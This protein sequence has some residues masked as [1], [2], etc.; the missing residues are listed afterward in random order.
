MTSCL[1]I[2]WNIMCTHIRR[3]WMINRSSRLSTSKKNE[4]V[5][6]NVSSI[7]LSLAHFRFNDTQTTR[8]MHCLLPTPPLLSL[9][10]RTYLASSI[11]IYI[12]SKRKRENDRVFT[13]SKSKFYI[14]D[15]HR[16]Q[17]ILLRSVF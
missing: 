16:D 11:Y 3:R 6:D 7:L 14:N 1:I 10:F 9:L 5:D 15:E 12:N 17:L 2:S 8:E 4:Y 13:N